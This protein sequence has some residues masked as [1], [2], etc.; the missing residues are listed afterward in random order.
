MEKEKN[1]A[2]IVILIFVLFSEYQLILII[3]YDSIWN[4]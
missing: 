1:I 4:S 3:I 2:I